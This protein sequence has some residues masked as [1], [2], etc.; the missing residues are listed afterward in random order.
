MYGGQLIQPTQ[1]NSTQSTRPSRSGTNE[2]NGTPYRDNRSSSLGG[3]GNGSGSNL[4]GTTF[5][6]TPL[7]QTFEQSLG[8]GPSIPVQMDQGMSKDPPP[9]TRARSGT[10]KSIKDKKSVFGVLSGEYG[11]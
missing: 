1:S 8:L 2:T 3:S 10:G 7:E 9:I 6:S 4:T 5:V 11:V